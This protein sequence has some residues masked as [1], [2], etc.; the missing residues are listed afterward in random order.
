MA[1]VDNYAPLENGFWNIS[2][3]SPP[4]S[5]S[6][7]TGVCGFN[8]EH[9]IDSLWDVHVL[10]PDSKPFVLLIRFESYATGRKWTHQ[11]IPNKKT[12]SSAPRSSQCI[13]SQSHSQFACFLFSLR[14]PEMCT[15]F[16]T[17]SLDFHELC[18]QVKTKSAFFRFLNPK[19]RIQMFHICVLKFKWIFFPGFGN[20]KK[21]MIHVL[22]WLSLV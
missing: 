13:Y 10:Q 18:W 14:L 3:H 1:D 15:Q 20:D 5:V 22:F 11:K 2:T 8:S 7:G 21:Y 17:G 12:S 4:Q 6:F 9:S 16:A 19:F